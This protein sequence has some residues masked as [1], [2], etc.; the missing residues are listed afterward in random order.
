MSSK[1]QI[2]IG[3]DLFVLA[4]QEVVMIGQQKLQLY[5]MSNVPVICPRFSDSRQI[6]IQE[7]R[8][9]L[10]PHAPFI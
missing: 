3:K 7:E 1:W 9:S 2:Q 4:V 10:K 5:F 6:P 8:C